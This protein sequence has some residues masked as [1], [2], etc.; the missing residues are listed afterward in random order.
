MQNRFAKVSIPQ[1]ALKKA[2]QHLA[3][4]ADH[5]S[6]D[7][8][9]VRYRRETLPVVTAN[10]VIFNLHPCH[11][12]ADKCVSVSKEKIYRIHTYINFLSDTNNWNEDLQFKGNVNPRDISQKALKLLNHTY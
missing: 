10:D 4:L 7:S 3:I 9:G 5:H 8:D 2:K 1:D 11:K 12:E 6:W